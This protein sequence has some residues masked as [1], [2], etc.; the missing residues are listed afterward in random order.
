MT[1]EATGTLDRGEHVTRFTRF[2]L[3]VSLDVPDGVSDEQARRLVVR[4]E[5][6]CLIG[7]SLNAPCYVNVLI[8]VVQNAI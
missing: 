2:D 8:R 6:S 7:N 3:Q 1:C 5:Q 4:A